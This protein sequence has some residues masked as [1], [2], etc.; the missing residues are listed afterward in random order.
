MYQIVYFK[1]CFVILRPVLRFGLKTYI[2]AVICIRLNF[3]QR[4]TAARYLSIVTKHKLDTVGTRKPLKVR[5]IDFLTMV[6]TQ[7]KLSKKV[8]TI[9]GEK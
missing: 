1:Q 2:A 4:T 7:G 9:T 6:L 5:N 3:W 8:R